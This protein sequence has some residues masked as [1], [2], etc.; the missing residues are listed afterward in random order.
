[1]PK[2]TTEIHPVESQPNE[3]ARFPYLDAQG[4]LTEKALYH[5][6]KPFDP[7]DL[8][9][10]PTDVK[11]K[12]GTETALALVY[13]DP[14]VYHERLDLVFG[15]GNWGMEIQFTT[16]PFFKAIPQKMGW[17]KDS[18]KVIQEARDVNGWKLFA[19]CSLKIEGLSVKSSTGEE[20]T[21]DG[22]AG[23]SAEA[24]A[25]KRACSTV[26]IGRYFYGFPRERM[27]Y[28]YGKFERLPEL[29]D[30]AIP[31]PECSVTTMPIED[32]T[33][34]NKKGEEETWPIDKVVAQSTKLF[35]VPLSGPI[36]MEKVK[37]LMADKAAAEATPAAADKEES[38][39]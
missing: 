20:D 35:G 37:K 23:T 4:R 2:K 1:M 32:F 38:A 28:A 36:F 15:A 17:G 9:W 29:P 14:R 6:S 10:L 33:F 25:F 34:T 31:R 19:V 12:D 26:G 18:D 27:P 3:F 24:Q 39:A 22:N 7:R 5:L 11:K 30:F 13:A 21:S 8:K 16:A